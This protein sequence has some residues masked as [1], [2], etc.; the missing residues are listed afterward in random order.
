MIKI[1]IL[2]VKLVVFLIILFS[3]SGFAQHYECLDSLVLGRIKGKWGSNG[4]TY[5]LKR[6]VLFDKS[7]TN[8]IHEQASGDTID[9]FITR[10]EHKSPS[11]FLVRHWPGPSEDPIFIFYCIENT[12]TVY[13]GTFYAD[14]VII[15]GNGFVYTQSRTNNMFNIIRK[16]EIIDNT[17]AEVEQPYYWVGL[18]SK[19]L[20]DVTLYSD[21]CMINPVANLT[22]DQEVMVLLNY[23][24]LYLI[25]TPFGLTGWIRIEFINCGVITDIYRLGD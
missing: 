21:T 24:D 11:Q 8:I 10:L 7:I 15:P 13:F 18:Q 20:Q 17:F 22:K 23:N 3:G 2:V 5:D 6:M 16:Y 9:L 1:R 4:P 12:D 14:I 19:L 25:K